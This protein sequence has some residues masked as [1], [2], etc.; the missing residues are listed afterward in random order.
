M[1]IVSH[2]NYFVEG[3]LTI[4]Y[5]AAIVCRTIHLLRLVSY[6]GVQYNSSRC[7]I[8]FIQVSNTMEKCQKGDLVPRIV[9]VTLAALQGAAL[10][11][12]DRV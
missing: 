2:E 10:V 5:E 7:L 8:Q 11:A 12:L 1:W 9:A 3:A 4:G 6:T